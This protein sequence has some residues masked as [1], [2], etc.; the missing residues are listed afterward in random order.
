MPFNLIVEPNTPPLSRKQFCAT[1]KGPAIALDGYVYGGPFFE[2]KGPY[3][4]FNH[5]ERVDRLATRATCGQVM[6]AICQGLFQ[7][8]TDDDGEPQG[9]VYIND[10]DEDCCTSWTLLKHGKMI[11]DLLESK[12]PEDQI[13]I[14]RLNRL[15]WKED[16]LDATAGA[17]CF[18]PEMPI[19]QKIAWIFKPYRMFRLAGGTREHRDE[20]S[21]R[22]VIDNV[23]SK[24]LQYVEGYGKS[25]TLDTTYKRIG[26]GKNWVMVEEIG[27]HARTGM[28]VDGIRAYVSVRQRA[29]GMYDYTIAR[30]SLFVKFPIP[31]FKN[32]FNKTEAC[33]DDRWG[34]SHICIGSPL[35]GGSALSPWFVEREINRILAKA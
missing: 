2:E 15:V 16:L 13:K 26:G 34:G 35:I 22:E 8:L 19:I 21:F 14:T 9:D 18:R 10:C 25:I 29:N 28:F 20:Q 4:N 30:M 27:M 3:I 31:K 6:L 33:S 7:S 23:E 17:Y 12:D 5:H 24:I 32:F 11:L 1:K